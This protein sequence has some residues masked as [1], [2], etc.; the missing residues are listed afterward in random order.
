METD[1]IIRA[2]KIASE[3][4]KYARSIIK[5]GTPLLEIA[6]KIESKITEL[7]GKPAFPTNLSINNIA[8]HYTPGHD[9]KT[10]AD[11]LLKVDFGVHVDGW[12]ADNAFSLDLEGNEE[13]KNLIEASEKALEN[14]LKI[15][16]KD[17]STD[18]I[19]GA[20]G[21]TIESYDFS[22]VINLSGHSMEKY[23][24]HSGINIPNINDKKNI[25]LGEGFYAV[26]PFATT[27]SGRIH[28]GKPSGIYYLKEIK[29]VR[30]PAARE[31]LEF[32]KKEYN[33]LPFCSRWIVK[34]L[35]TKAL[36]GLR[37]LEA[38]GNLHHFPQ[39][40]EVRGSKVSQ[41]EQT[42]LISKEKGV[43]VTTE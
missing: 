10:P 30:S 13:N 3:V 17:V 5:K 36:F 22:P 16:K 19:G 4:K 15:M 35:G 6:E 2:G 42:V 41:A 11:G 28:D 32:I 27:G 23:N 40:V 21:E 7:G 20:I 34:K 39:L 33:T 37:E 38:R 14:A 31:V 1:K 43:I 9:D 12:T 26:E 18:E 8:A 29:N 24:L 25:L